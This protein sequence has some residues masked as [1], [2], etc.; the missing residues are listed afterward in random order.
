MLKKQADIMILITN[1][2][3]HH[4]ATSL[5]VPNLSGKSSSKSTSPSPFKPLRNWSTL[6]KL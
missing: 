5:V 2:R 1:E 6:Y 4:H 3:R